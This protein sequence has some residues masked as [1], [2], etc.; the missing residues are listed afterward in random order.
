MAMI[1]FFCACALLSASVVSFQMEDS[2]SVCLFFLIYSLILMGISLLIFLKTRG[3]SAFG[4]RDAFLVVVLSWLVVI[5]IGAVPFQYL[6]GF[7]LIDAVFEATSGFTTTG[8]SVIDSNLI[9]SNGNTLADGLLG[10]PK[11]LLYWRSMTHW[12]GGMGI[13]VLFIAIIPHLGIAG[14]MLYKTEVSGADMSRSMRVADTAKILWGVYVLFSATETI[15]LCIGGMSLFDAWCYTCGTIATGGFSTYPSSVSE[16]NSVFIEAVITIF[17]FIGS[18]NFILHYQVIRKG[19]ANYLKDEEFRSHL[20]ITFLC[21]LVVTLSIYGKT[22]YDAAGRLVEPTLFNAIRYAS[23]QTVSMKS[24]TGFCTADFDKWPEISR[25]I[26]L[27]LVIVGGCGGSTS[28]A[29]KHSRFILLVKYSIMQVRRS[30]F[31]HAISNISI[32]KN[33]VDSETLHRV[34]SFFFVYIAISTIGIILL[35]SQI[36]ND[37]ITSI[38]AVFTCIGGAGPGLAKV[39]AVCTYSWMTSF[40]KIVLSSLMLMGRLEIFVL[41]VL[42]LPRYWKK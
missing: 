29:I 30:L 32:D 28:G 38:S 18:C 17:M 16:F 9:L 4:T 5:V 12:L 6:T 1:V 36:G 39:G 24:T 19:F 15:L 23:F 8:A 20:L 3:I 31:P 2:L 26:L 37:L 21:I 27:L 25:F 40:S 33:R 13:I 22:I 10:L 7:T 41:L 42:F 34:L 35:C 11:G 14:K